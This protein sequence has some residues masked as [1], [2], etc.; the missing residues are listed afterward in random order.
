MSGLGERPLKGSLPHNLTQLGGE[1][2]I[3]L[4]ST[5]PS[6]QGHSERGKV[7]GP[8]PYMP[9]S[10]RPGSRSDSSVPPSA[11]RLPS[12]HYASALLFDLHFPKTISVPRSCPHGAHGLQET[13]RHKKNY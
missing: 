10:G 12:L 7:R 9:G 3:L 1:A 6:S 4:V 5:I 2:S 8:S 11:R 13:N